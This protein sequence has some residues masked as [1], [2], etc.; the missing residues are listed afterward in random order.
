MRPSKLLGCTMIVVAT[1]AAG[2]AAQAAAAQE[3]IYIVRHA[4]RLDDSPD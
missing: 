1:V 3:A 4:E 2:P